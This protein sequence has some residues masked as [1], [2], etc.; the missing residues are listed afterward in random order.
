MSGYRQRLT[1]TGYWPRIV[2]IAAVDGL[3]GIGSRGERRGGFRF[4]RC[5]SSRR[6][7]W[8]IRFNQRCD[9]V[10]RAARA[11]TGGEEFERHAACGRGEACGPCDD[12][13]VVHRRTEGNRRLLDVSSIVEGTHGGTVVDLSGH[14]S[15]ALLESV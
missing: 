11:V 10:R 6:W 3:V 8:R 9:L 7:C 4:L 12:G 5:G 14:A 1:A 13:L 2:G 15:R